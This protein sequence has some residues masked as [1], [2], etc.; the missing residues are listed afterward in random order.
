MK[1][2]A[3]ILALFLF[4]FILP[5]A[6][7]QN[8]AQASGIIVGKVTS[9]A[10]TGIEKVWVRVYNLSNL[11]KGQAQTDASGNF[12][13]Q[14]L[15]TDQYR[16]RFETYSAGNYLPE[17]YNDKSSFVTAD[18]VAVTDGAT[19]SGIDAQLAVGGI[20]AGTVTNVSSAGIQN[21]SAAAFDSTGAYVNS[22]STD[23]S[24][25]Y[26]IQGL[27][28]G[29]YRL[30]FGTYSAG[31]Y[32]PEWYNDKSSLETADNIAVTPGSTTS[33]INAVLATAA[34]IS[35][36]VTNAAGAGA[37]SV[38]VTAYDLSQF[39]VKDGM[40]DASG[41][42]KIEGLPTG[43]YRVFFE[44]GYNTNDLSEWYNDKSSFDTADNISVTAGGA[45]VINAQLAAGGIISG[46]VTAPGGSGISSVYVTVYDL[47]KSSTKSQQT[48]SSGVYQVQGLP[49]GSYKVFF[50]TL[51][52]SSNFAPE[53]YNDKS[54]FAAADP[55]SVTAGATTSG[56]D[57]QLAAG[58]TIFGRLTGPSGAGIQGATA[59]AYDLNEN[60]VGSVTSDINGRYG[61][62]KLPSGVFKVYFAGPSGGGFIPEWYNNKSGFL[63]AT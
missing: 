38:F 47:K 32:F 41:N 17:W 58:G 25:N 20:I 30:Q 56:I 5:Y 31:N 1:K 46:T 12:R 48:N 33:G 53:W 8:D 57:A 6:L 14:Y 35:G 43:T 28:G 18:N 44:A 42:Y 15:A 52:A 34:A 60:Y 49:T 62:Q 2:S 61:I 11:S 27:P 24:G 36:T 37:S 19:T 10:G 16:V 3:V 21:V 23:A 55:V 54:K 50:Q 13:V 7:G 4:C 59:R 39:P 51:Y 45:A 26:S 29:N 63:S 40:T 22:G 9:P